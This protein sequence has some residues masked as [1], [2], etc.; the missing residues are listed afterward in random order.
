MFPYRRGGRNIQQLLHGSDMMSFLNNKNVNVCSRSGEPGLH[1]RRGPRSAAAD[2]SVAGRGWAQQQYSVSFRTGPG[3]PPL[4]AQQPAPPRSSSHQHSLHWF[5]H[6][7]R[8]SDRTAERRRAAA[9]TTATPASQRQWPCVAL[10]LLSDK[11]ISVSHRH[12]G[13]LFCWWA[14]SS[15]SQP[16]TFVMLHWA[17]EHCRSC[18]HADT[19]FSSMCS[20]LLLPWI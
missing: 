20:I 3:Q 5:L 10:A 15:N 11:N 8:C 9:T 4:D 19:S 6:G 18:V 12:Q 16:V 1:A 17:E 14:E 7:G 13:H 2:P